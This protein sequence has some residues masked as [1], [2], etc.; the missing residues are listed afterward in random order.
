MICAVPLIAADDES[1]FGGKAVSLGRS[2]QAGL[3]VPPGF[4][5]DVHA[6][7]ALAAK[8]AAD[9]NLAD[10]LGA[11]GGRAAVRSSAVG[12][13]A[14]DASFAGQH[15][16]ILNAASSAG[17]LHA[18]VEVWRSAHSASALLYRER[19][20]IAGTPRIAVVIQH[21]VDAGAAGVLF[22]RNPAS[23]A[24]EILIEAAWGLGESVVSGAVVP[25]SYRISLDGQVLERAAGIKDV[26][27]RISPHGGTVEI[28]V[29]APRAYALVL[30]D[31]Q[32]ER[33]H[34]LTLRCEAIFGED[35]DIEW[36]FEDDV[37]Y[38]LQCR[39]ITSAAAP[40]RA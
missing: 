13:D 29:E 21:L 12:E 6:V 30:Q 27:L 40:S 35:L 17:L 4:A 33:L 16:T 5:F 28:A 31:S 37:L 32:L 25:D 36:A 15:L 24:R 7:D 18:I 20:G 26:E 14:R 2:I 1:R 11:V 19:M 3:P 38:M 8:G 9:E 39:A 23:G 22:T 34:A 10:L